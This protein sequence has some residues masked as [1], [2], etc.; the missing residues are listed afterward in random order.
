M[1][2][3]GKIETQIVD[4]DEDV[5]YASPTDV[6]AHIRNKA[7][8]DLTNEHTGGTVG[9]TSLTRTD[10]RKLLRR[11]TDK[12]D[13]QTKRAWRRRRVEAYEVRIKFDSSL[14][15]AKNRR[16]SRRGSGGIAMNSGRRG[17]GDLPH[18]HVFPIDPAE[19]D[20]VEVLNPRSVN[21]ITD[22]GGRED[23]RF[24]VDE[25]KGIIRPDVSL[26]VPTG[27]KRRGERDIQ[28]AKLRVSYRYGYDPAPDV[29]D[30]VDGD[31]GVRVSTAVPGDLRDAVALLVAARLVGSDQYGSLVPSGSDDVSLADAVSSFK[32]EAN[33]TIDEYR[34]P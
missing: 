5:V 18:I 30:E 2:T 19:G 1:R 32:A 33:D 4:A 24:V 16:R 17:M 7:Y 31:G 34:R 23:G 20:V 14:K 22:A 15:Y 26:F 3:S 11:F 13:N 27:R 29:E 10:V 9:E 12:I 25:R 6:F 28:F 21:D 8:S